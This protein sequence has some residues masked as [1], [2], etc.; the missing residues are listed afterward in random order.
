MRGPIDAALGEYLAFREK[1]FKEEQETTH[2][3]VARV[4]WFLL[5]FVV[6]V[7]VFSA[8][9]SV[10]ISRSVTQPLQAGVGILERI[11]KGDISRTWSN[12]FAPGKTRSANWRA[13]CRP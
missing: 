5:V 8:L 11:S 6:A 2:A 4:H 12:R 9:Q 7:L 3:A 10:F 13:P 1:R